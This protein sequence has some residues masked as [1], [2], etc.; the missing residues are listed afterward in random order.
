MIYEIQP[1]S[2]IPHL[3]KGDIC[4]INGAEYPFLGE[5]DAKKQVPAKHGVYYLKPVCQYHLR[6]EKS[7]GVE[8]LFGSDHIVNMVLNDTAPVLR[9]RINKEIFNVPI[10]PGDNYLKVILKNVI[11]SMQIDLRDYKPKFGSDNRMNNMRRLLVGDQ[12][13]TYEK[14]LEWFDILGYSNEILVYDPDGK[15]VE[16]N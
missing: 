12:N 6:H 8:K 4:V 16:F 10:Q 15:L 13:L 9:E 2:V 7:N 1:G 11:N 3:I 5:F 14:F